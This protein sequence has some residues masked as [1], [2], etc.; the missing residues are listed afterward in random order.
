MRR[1]AIGGAVKE[2][3]P[4]MTRSQAWI[5]AELPTVVS[6]SS[7]GS[8][9]PKRE[10]CRRPPRDSGGLLAQ[11]W[12][13]TRG[14]TPQAPQLLTW[15]PLVALPVCSGGGRSGE[16]GRSALSPIASPGRPVW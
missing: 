16:E 13:K 3:S 5:G 15:R 6:I 14:E 12:A 4:S 7:L 2:P 9:L 11:S 8:D 1:I 10:N